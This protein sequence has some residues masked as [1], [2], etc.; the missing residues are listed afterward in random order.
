MLEALKCLFP[1]AAA[2]D[3]LLSPSNAI[4]LKYDLYRL[5]NTKWAFSMKI[6]GNSNS[7]EELECKTLSSL[8]D[9]KWKVKVTT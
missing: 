6:N 8:M 1:N 4:K 9:I 5:K 7:T 2:D 3:N